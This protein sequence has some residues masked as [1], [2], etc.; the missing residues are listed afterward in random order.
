MSSSK[1]PLPHSLGFFSLSPAWKNFYSSHCYNPCSTH[2]LTRRFQQSGQFWLASRC[3]C[4]FGWQP[5]WPQKE[6]WGIRR[7]ER[8]TKARFERKRKSHLKVLR[9]LFSGSQEFCHTFSGLW[10][11]ETYFLISRKV[12]LQLLVLASLY[13]ITIEMSK[14]EDEFLQSVPNCSGLTSTLHH[15]NL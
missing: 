11:P 14:A 15:F 9:P 2:A 1:I 4:G 3:H 8:N 5:N 6:W 13:K 10:A 12:M 7:K